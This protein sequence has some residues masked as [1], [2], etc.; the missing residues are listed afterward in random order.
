MVWLGFLS[1]EMWS[2]FWFIL[3]IN[4]ILIS[5][6]KFGS[7]IFRL[8][9]SC[10]RT[11]VTSLVSAWT[12]LYRVVGGFDQAWV[13]CVVSREE[14]LSVRGLDFLRLFT[15]IISATLTVC[16]DFVISLLGVFVK[17]L[18][19]M[20]LLMELRFGHNFWLQILGVGSVFE[21]WIALLILVFK[22]VYVGIGLVL[23]P[24]P[25]IVVA[26]SGG[27]AGTRI[28]HLVLVTFIFVY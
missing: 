13:L 26:L 8:R 25:G 1:F 24:V 4:A 2:G 21:V 19:K 9:V 3:R 22:R 15:V 20:I 18:V 27:L 16:V 23:Y 10:I 6:T 5:N 17:L 7:L 11:I 14:A 28:E 12:D